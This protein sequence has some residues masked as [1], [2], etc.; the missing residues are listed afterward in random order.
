[1]ILG[2]GDV[3]PLPKVEETKE[4]EATSGRKIDQRR[5]GGSEIAEAWSGLAWRRRE[6]TQDAFGLN[7]I[8]YC[9]RI[10]RVG[11]GM[12]KFFDWK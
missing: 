4:T 8:G 11:M 5:V 3:Q 12:E 1:M 2:K 10:S 6:V 9:Y 7:A